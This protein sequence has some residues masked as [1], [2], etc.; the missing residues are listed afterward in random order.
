MSKYRSRIDFSNMYSCDKQGYG[1]GLD[2]QIFVRRETTQRTFNAPRIGTQG[3]SEGA[4]SASTDISAGSDNALK[5]A[6]DGG[7]VVDVTLTLTGFTMKSILRRL[8]LLQQ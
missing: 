5:V 2:A 3:Q 6:V 1:I 4:A 7:T 8:G